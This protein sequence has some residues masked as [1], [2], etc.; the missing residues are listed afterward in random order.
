MPSWKNKFLFEIFTAFCVS[1]VQGQ[2]ANS[3]VVV[4]VI[5]K[6]KM[7]CNWF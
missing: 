1:V 3:H 6:I 2:A 7:A 4:G 5:R